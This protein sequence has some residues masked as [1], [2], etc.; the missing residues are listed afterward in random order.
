MSAERIRHS[1]KKLEQALIPGSTIQFKDVLQFVPHQAFYQYKIDNPIL[2]ESRASLLTLT[3]ADERKK[4]RF[5][6]AALS[7]Y[8]FLYELQAIVDSEY[9]REQINAFLKQIKK[10]ARMKLIV[11]GAVGLGVGGAIAASLFTFLSWSQIECVIGATLFFPIAGLVFTILKMGYGLYTNTRSN[12]SFGRALVDNTFLLANA[13]LNMLAYIALLS[14]A[15]AFTS[16]AS[17]LFIAATCINAIKDLVFLVQHA[18]RNLPKVD[19]CFSLS[20][21][22]S[23][24][25]EHYAYKQH[26]NALTIKA[27]S[28]T[29][30]IGVM[31]FWCLMPGGIVVTGLAIVAMLLL[32]LAQ[33]KALSINV[34][35]QQNGLNESFEQLEKNH[36]DNQVRSS[37]SG[38][39]RNLDSEVNRHPPET[40]AFSRNR[41][42]AHSKEK[43]SSHSEGC[44]LALL[45][46]N[47]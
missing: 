15:S 12:V 25:R 19:E 23:A 8:D 6:N 42:F 7:V 11:L 1:L 5:N 4:M 24:L 3:L 37:Y 28:A 39:D 13:V 44:Y 2:R 30:M 9:Q 33:S 36:D 20:D 43:E 16:V 27:V 35:R 47:A 40:G 18:R 34:K 41:F 29:A 32:V 26:R 38:E 14:A 10:R 31:T 21:K 46:Q 22:Q 17:G 45:P